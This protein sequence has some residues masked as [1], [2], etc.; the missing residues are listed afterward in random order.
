MWYDLSFIFFAT[1]LWGRQDRLLLYHLKD[2]E[3]KAQRSQG[4]QESDR[5]ERTFN[6][7]ISCSL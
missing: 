1:T 5:L 6:H 3:A 7:E 2:S 4:L